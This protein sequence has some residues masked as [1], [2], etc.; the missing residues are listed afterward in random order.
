MGYHRAMDQPPKKRRERPFWFW[1]S[2]GLA[3]GSLL[4]SLS[5]GPAC[6]LDCRVT[7]GGEASAAF[8]DLYYPFVA[9]AAH[10]RYG[11]RRPIWWYAGLGLPAEIVPGSS[12]YRDERKVLHPKIFWVGN[13][14]DSVPLPFPDSAPASGVIFPAGASGGAP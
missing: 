13:N 6:W 3:G 1:A 12:F 2:V 4:Y 7:G 9:L 8:H 5:F 11:L 10:G 14:F